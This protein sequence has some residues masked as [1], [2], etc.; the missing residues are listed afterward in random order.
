M[1]WPSSRAKS[2]N[3]AQSGL[4]VLDIDVVEVLAAGPCL[5]ALVERAGAVVFR[6]KETEASGEE[7]GRCE[8]GG[9]QVMARA[10]ERRACLV[11]SMALRAA[12]VAAM[13]AFVFAL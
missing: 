5:D 1:T 12:S 3:R 13:G 2:R 9:P 8:H 11:A 6:V 7:V 10:A 4:I